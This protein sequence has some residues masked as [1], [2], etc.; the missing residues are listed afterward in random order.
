V[1]PVDDTAKD[2][3]TKDDTKPDDADK[4]TK[5]KDKKLPRSKTRPA[6]SD[7]KKKN[8]PKPNKKTARFDRSYT[9][10]QGWRDGLTREEVEDI[11]N[12]GL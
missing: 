2:D 9:A 5:S 12:G 7:E 4:D 3:T 8:A 10:S 1:A 11:V 6:I